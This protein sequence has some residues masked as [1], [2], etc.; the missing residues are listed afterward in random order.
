MNNTA[1]WT[2]AIVLSLLAHAGAAK[3]FGPGEKPPEQALVAGGDAMEVTV[4]G[5]AF[6]EM[7]QAGD[8]TEAMEPEEV[9]PEEVEPAPVEAADV[10]PIQAEVTAETP[11]DIVPTEAD[12]ILPAEEISPVAAEQPEITATVAP[13]ETVVPEEK[14]EMVKPEPEKKPEPK[15]EPEKE[16]PQKKKLVKKKAGDA[17]KQTETLN[18]GQA[19]GVKN[20][21]T[22]SSTGKKG[23]KSQ[24]SGNAAESN[25]KGKVRS[26]VQR[27]FRYPKAA[28]RAGIRGTVQVS[29]TIL[30]NGGVSGARISKSSGSPVLD[31][32]ALNAVRGAEPFPKIPDAANRG[33]WPFTIPLQFGR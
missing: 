12:V 20:A 3:L 33:S 8:P 26:K 6:E 30:A 19:D 10:T 4:L 14:P 2:G 16:K 29:F 5:N 21:V 27:H 17:G 23:A 11:T 18:K 13:V 15:K 22:S 32:A 1:K 7:I 25:Y 9:A 28:D 31:E 24:A